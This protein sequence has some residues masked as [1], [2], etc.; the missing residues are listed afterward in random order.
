MALFI[1]K[2]DINH[3]FLRIIMFILAGN[4]YKIYL[5]NMIFDL[6]SKGC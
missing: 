1:Y 4:Y 3:T 6:N 5:F 2:A